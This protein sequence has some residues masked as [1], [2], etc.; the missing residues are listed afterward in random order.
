MVGYPRAPD[1]LQSSIS[2]RLAVGAECLSEHER[3]ISTVRITRK[4]LG[5]ILI[6]V[7]PFTSL[8][9]VDLLLDA[10]LFGF[11]AIVWGVALVWILCSSNL[12]GTK[13]IPPRWYSSGPH[14]IGEVDSSVDPSNY[15]IRRPRESDRRLA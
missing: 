9:V 10:S 6:A 2:Q 13:R 4:L 7:V 8:W 15:A 1:D 11:F 3:E 5:H 12:V 14:I